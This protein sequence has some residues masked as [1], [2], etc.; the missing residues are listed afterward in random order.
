MPDTDVPDITDVVTRAWGDT[1][2]SKP[3]VQVGDELDHIVVADGETRYLVPVSIGAEVEFGAPVPIPAGEPIQAA[4][5]V[6]TL[7]NPNPT[8]V[9]AA[10]AVSVDD[11]RAAYYRQSPQH[12]WIREIHTNPLRLIVAS[13]ADGS[14]TR[15]DVTVGD[16][17]SIN[18][19]EPVPVRI[20]YEEIPDGEPTAAASTFVYASAAESRPYSATVAAAQISHRP[21]SDFSQADYTPAQWRRACLIDRGPD[22]GTEDTKQRYA[23][24]VREPDGTLNRNAVHAAAARI[25]QVEGITDTQRAEAARELVRLYRQ[26]LGEEPPEPLLTL[27]TTTTAAAAAVVDELPAAEP[28]NPDNPNEEDNMSLTEVRSRLGLAD[29]ADET[30]ILAAIDTLRS[31]AQQVAAAADVQAANE[32]LSREVELLRGQV[33]DLSQQVAAAAAEKREALKKAVL[34]EAQN[35]GK[36]TPAERPQWEAD[37]DRAP[38]VVTRVLASIAPGTRVPVAPVGTVGNPIDSVDDLPPEP[39]GLFSNP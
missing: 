3:I 21:W 13:D 35:A 33:Q 36:F 18:F 23:L 16:D 27:T 8:V 31:Q 12:V 22:H 4:A 26:E 10:A 32:S 39:E 20:R 29:D 9:H 34:D 38:E 19:S 37:Y 2:P 6:I 11:V 14:V 5:E 25:N 15:V 17:G 7:P 24:P 30:A 28:G 1:N